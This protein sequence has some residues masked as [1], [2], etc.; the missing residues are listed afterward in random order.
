MQSSRILKAVLFGYES[1]NA[2]SGIVFT[3]TLAAS[4]AQDPSVPE[5]YSCERFGDFSAEIPAFARTVSSTCRTNLLYWAGGSTPA[6]WV[7]KSK[8]IHL[9]LWR[10]ASIETSEK[11]SIPL[12]VAVG[13]DCVCAVFEG[14]VLMRPLPVIL[15][16]RCNTRFLAWPGPGRMACGLRNALNHAYRTENEKL[17]R[18]C[19]DNKQVMGLPAAIF[20]CGRSRHPKLPCLFGDW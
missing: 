1:F 13:T 8:S 10:A 18:I 16:F 5:Q 17:L 11:S 6:G 15:L 14:S 19:I 3:D 12:V 7:F 20:H 9:A 2:S 4:A